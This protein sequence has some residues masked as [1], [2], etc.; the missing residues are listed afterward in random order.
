MDD[1]DTRQTSPDRR[2]RATLGGSD[3]A[4][5]RVQATLAELRPVFA[6]ELT[7]SERLAAYARLEDALEQVLPQGTCVVVNL[8][9]MSH[10][11]AATP[12]DALLLS[13]AEFGKNSRGYS[14]CVGRPTTVGAGLW[15]S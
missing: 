11:T 10:V 3:A 15:H 1:V 14:F 5:A 13:I 12:V 7:D 6:T 9:S 4:R 8:A 2:S